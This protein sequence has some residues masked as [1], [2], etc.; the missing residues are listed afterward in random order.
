M[1]PLSQRIAEGA[2]GRGDFPHRAITESIIGAAIRVQKALGPGL[3]ESAY[4]SC[5]IYELKKSGH[6]VTT[7]VPLDIHYGELRIEAAY[8]LDLLVDDAVIVELKTVE[9]ILDLH[10]AQLH[11][12]LRF[13]EK[14]VGLLLNFWAW[15]LKDGGIERIVRSRS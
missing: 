3:F 12:Y 5:L 9:R 7:Q 1:K 4:E 13:S 15:P 8:R 6:R 10:R 2:E 11:S 14:E